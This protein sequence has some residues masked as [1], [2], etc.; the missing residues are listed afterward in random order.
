MGG[1]ERKPKQRIQEEKVAILRRHLVEKV[2][3]SNL[4]EESGV[5]PTVLYGWLKQFLEQGGA[6]FPPPERSSRREE[7]LKQRIEALEAKLRRKDE[8]LAEQMEEQ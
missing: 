2:P 7:S 4:C 8:V 5:H 6:A 1:L 3:V